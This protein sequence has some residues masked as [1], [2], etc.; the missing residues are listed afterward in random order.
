VIT[1]EYKQYCDQ[2]AAHP[3]Q[4]LDAVAKKLQIM[5]D[6]EL[7]RALD[8]DKALISNVRNK[9]LGI[10]TSLILRILHRTDLG[11]RDLLLLVKNPRSLQGA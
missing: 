4:L 5:N 8:V 9:R 7:A 10:G 1:T 3:N 2:L 6:A 11:T